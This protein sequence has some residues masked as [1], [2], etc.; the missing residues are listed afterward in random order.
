MFNSVAFVIAAL[1]ASTVVTGIVF[2]AAPTSEDPSPA[3][4]FSTD[5]R[6]IPGW[7]AGAMFGTVVFRAMRKKD[8]QL[9]STTQ[10]N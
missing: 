4:I 2:M 9:R 5:W 7:V 1:L 3:W 6:N 8:R 10:E